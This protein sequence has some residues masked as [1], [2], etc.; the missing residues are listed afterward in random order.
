MTDEDI[1]IGKMLLAAGADSA[2][3]DFEGLTPDKVA[4]SDAAKA[5][6][7]NSEVANAIEKAVENNKDL[8]NEVEQNRPSFKL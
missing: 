1:Q 2:I 8:D 7:L 4:K 5:V 3:R 6:L